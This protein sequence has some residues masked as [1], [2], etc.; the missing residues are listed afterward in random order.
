[1]VRLIATDLDGTLL[2]SDRQ[3]VSVRTREALAAARDAGITIVLVSARGPRGVAEVAKAA[4]CDGLAICSNGALVPDLGA[5]EVVRHR[6]L[7]AEVAAKLIR[8]LRICLSDVCFATEI[9]GEFALEPAFEGAGVGR[10]RLGPGTPMRS[11]SSP[12]R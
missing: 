9:E 8:A 2:R 11:S 5:C 6:P 3:T 7:P 10:R 4:E 1:L 12:R